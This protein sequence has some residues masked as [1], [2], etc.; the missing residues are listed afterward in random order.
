MNS[1]LGFDI[2][3]RDV[4]NRHMTLGVR[5]SG[6]AALL[7]SVA[8]ADEAIAALEGGADVIDAKDPAH[9]SLGAVGLEALAE[10]QAAVRNRAVL[11]AALGDASDVHR[12]ER[13]ATEYSSR[14]ASLVKVG[15]A[16]V[17]D[18]RRVD[19][20][21]AAAVRGCAAGSGVVAVAYADS[22]YAESIDAWSLVDV[23]VRSGARGVLVDTADK[24][25]E[26]LM[27]LWTPTQ[28]ASWVADAR[29]WGLIAAVAGRL[30]PS[31]VAIVRDAGADVVG[32]RGAA[33]IGDRNSRVSAERVRALRA[34][35]DDQPTSPD[36][37]AVDTVA[38]SASIG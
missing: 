8:D 17:A 32:V 27:S 38:E 29:S 15:F 30:G 36:G 14:G 35:L 31:D 12:T 19:A 11:T 2:G 13:L 33:C 22:A 6:S 21:L 34:R 5:F 20:L 24:L 23:A 26:G 1:R 16:G 37:A 10:I 18:A 9:G 28:I 4:Y 3:S 7:V 25:G